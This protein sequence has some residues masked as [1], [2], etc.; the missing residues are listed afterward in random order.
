MIFISKK[1]CLKTLMNSIT[2]CLDSLM[3][4]T[5]SSIYESKCDYHDALV[6]PEIKWNS[7][8]YIANSTTVEVFLTA[9]LY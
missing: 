7:S 1:K 5:V 3:G 4:M 8:Q 6:P 2:H 9:R